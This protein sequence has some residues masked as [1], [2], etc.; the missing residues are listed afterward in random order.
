MNEWMNEWMDVEYWLNDNWQ[1][2]TLVVVLLILVVVVVTEFDLNPLLGTIIRL[3]PGSHS[4][5]TLSINYIHFVWLIKTTHN[6]SKY[7]PKSINQ[8]FINASEYFL[9]GRLL[10]RI[11]KLVT[12]KFRVKRSTLRRICPS[13][14]CAPQIPH[15]NLWNMPWF[16]LVEKEVTSLIDLKNCT[17]HA[18]YC[19]LGSKAVQYYRNVCSIFILKVF[20]P[21]GGDL[22]PDCSASPIILWCPLESPL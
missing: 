1:Q 9:I 14:T 17:N 13:S 4:G 19:L 8:S 3:T 7:S 16:S 10:V 6:F 12:E 2:E 18:D 22:L 20:L 21:S 15:Q 11:Q 5:R